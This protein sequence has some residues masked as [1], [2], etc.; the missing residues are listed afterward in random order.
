MKKILLVLSFMLP[1]LGHAQCDIDFSYSI[2]NDTVSIFG[3]SNDTS[4]ATGQYNWYLNYQP[5]GTGQHVVLYNVQPGYYNFELSYQLQDSACY[6]SKYVKVGNFPCQINQFTYD[7]NDLNVTFDFNNSDTAFFS[8]TWDFGDGSAATG[9]HQSHAYQEPGTYLVTLYKSGPDTCSTSQYIEVGQPQSSPLFG[10]IT[11][12][13]YAPI[14]DNII[15]IYSMQETFQF[16]R[17]ITLDTGH[18]Y[19]NLPHGNYLILATPHPESVFF[20]SAA[21]TFYG[22]T[23]NWQSA[24][25]IQ[26]NESQSISI[27]LQEAPES[28][29]PDPVWL[30]GNDLIEGYIYE[31]NPNVRTLSNTGF[32][33]AMVAL[34][35]EFGQKLSV[36]FTDSEGKYTFSNLIAG[37]YTLKITYPGN[38]E[39]VI[40][41]VTLDGDAETLEDIEPLSWAKEYIILSVAPE[42]NVLDVSIIPNPVVEILKIKGPAASFTYEVINATGTVVNTG[43]ANSEA[44]VNM[45]NMSTGVYLV[46]IHS[47]RGSV[48]KQVVKR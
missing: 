35:N 5:A 19:L 23:A 33:N 16:E 45:A 21:P 44:T 36:T 31:S 25:V 8:Y 14:D 6:K 20:N 47:S 3:Y 12:N 9:W 18:F 43:T 15:S 37:T 11:F 41:E 48:T 27:K 7:V 22:N 46:K 24:M 30:S 26:H 38:N 29:I 10:T 17:S 40:L 28:T 13:S 32:E 4:S 1:I 34:Y 39:S 2:R 42:H